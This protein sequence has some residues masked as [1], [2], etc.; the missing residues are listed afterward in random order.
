MPI[1]DKVEWYKIENNPLQ[2]V[3]Q[4]SLLLIFITLLFYDLFMSSN[5]LIQI[6]EE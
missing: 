4:Q 6:K 5:K 2:A 3:I 1:N